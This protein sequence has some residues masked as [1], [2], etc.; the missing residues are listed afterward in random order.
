[1]KGAEREEGKWCARPAS[2]RS[3]QQ[4]LVGMPRMECDGAQLLLQTMLPDDAVAR[5][6]VRSVEGEESDDADSS[7]RDGQSVDD[8]G[9]E[10][11]GAMEGQW[12]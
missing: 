6:A 10:I 12:R 5:L 2:T 3:S 9:S 11:E 8:R 4:R 7:A 1:M